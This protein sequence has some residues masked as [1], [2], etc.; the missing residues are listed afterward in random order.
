LSHAEP[1][2]VLAADKQQVWDLIY[3]NACIVPVFL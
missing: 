3:P 2:L 1:N